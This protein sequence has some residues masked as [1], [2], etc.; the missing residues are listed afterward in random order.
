M[1]TM[2]VSMLFRPRTRSKQGKHSKSQPPHGGSCQ[3]EGKAMKQPHLL[4]EQAMTAASSLIT[5]SEARDG[6]NN[7][8]S[9][10]V[11]MRMATNDQNKKRIVT[12]R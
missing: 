9:G 12:E 11:R 8:G 7:T 3:S 2:V 5:S 6:R 4:V 10:Q 1:T